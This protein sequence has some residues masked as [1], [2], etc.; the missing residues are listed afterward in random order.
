VVHP[1]SSLRLTAMPALARW[2]I[3]TMSC[4]QKT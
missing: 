2:S 3:S 4:R 1:A